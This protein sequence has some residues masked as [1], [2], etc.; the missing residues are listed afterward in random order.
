MKRELT[1]EEEIYLIQQDIRQ[2]AQDIINH[3]GDLTLQL[4]EIWRLWSSAELSLD[5]EIYLG[6]TN[7]TDDL[8]R[9]P[10]GLERGRYNQEELEK[11]DSLEKKVLGFFG[12]KTFDFLAHEII[13]LLD[14]Y[15]PPDVK[16]EWGFDVYPKNTNNC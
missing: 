5:H 10:K 6:L 2:C 11:L 15:P 16:D 14:S 3:K 8:D 9:I 1:P 13:K 4:R 12:K 7:I